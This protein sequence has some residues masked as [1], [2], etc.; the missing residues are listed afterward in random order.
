ME[1]GVSVQLETH[2]N[3]DSFTIH[4]SLLIDSLFIHIDWLHIDFVYLK[5]AAL[6]IGDYCVFSMLID[7]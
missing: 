6:E 7:C 5:D 3:S 4:H 2:F 1:S